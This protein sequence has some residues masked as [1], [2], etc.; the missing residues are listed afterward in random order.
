MV[1]GD[2]EDPRYYRVSEDPTEYGLWM[3]FRKSWNL[4]GV[5]AS[6]V[7]DLVRAGVEVYSF[8]YGWDQ[9]DLGPGEYTTISDEDL[10]FFEGPF[11]SPDVV[12][13]WGPFAAELQP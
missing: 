9:G 7:P 5:D 6:E 13:S 10:D 8:G 4:Y 2:A 3:D 11:P 12:D 1:I